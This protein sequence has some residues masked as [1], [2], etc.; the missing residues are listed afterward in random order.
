MFLISEL[1]SEYEGDEPLGYQEKI[2]DALKIAKKLNQERLS[3]ILITH[4]TDSI[5]DHSALVVEV[6]KE[7]LK[8][9]GTIVDEKNQSKKMNE[10]KILELVKQHCLE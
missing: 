8:V 2:S 1:I 6:T 9:F 3:S 10:A 7:G 5:K 4:L